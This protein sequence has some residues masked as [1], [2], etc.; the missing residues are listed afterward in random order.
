[1]HSNRQAHR[2]GHARLDEFPARRA[3]PLRI[4]RGTPSLHGSPPLCRDC[5]PAPLDLETGALS[6]VQQMVARAFLP[7]SARLILPAQPQASGQMVQVAAV[8]LEI[9]GGCRP[10]APVPF[11]GGQD[12]ASPEGRH[13]LGF[14][15]VGFRDV[16]RLSR[17]FGGMRTG[18]GDGPGR[19]GATTR[20]PRRRAETAKFVR[21]Q[22]SLSR[23]ARVA[24]CTMAGTLARPSIITSACSGTLCCWISSASRTTAR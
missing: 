8:Q 12:L 3:C 7:H 13:A 20:A 18:R 21:R 10:V 23:I 2:P 15:D 4:L 17:L 1:M 11:H 24:C 9:A 6:S 22:G 14:R 16:A 5:D 19:S